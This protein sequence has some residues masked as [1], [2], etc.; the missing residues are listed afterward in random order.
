MNRIYYLFLVFLL[1][2]LT[3]TFAQTGKIVGNVTDKETGEPLIGANVLI[4]GTS[5]GAATDVEGEFLILNVPPGTYT[6]KTSFIGYQ[7]ISMSNIKVSVNLTTEAKFAISSEAIQAKEVL[8]VAERPLVD[9]NITNSTSVVAAEDIEN[10]PIRGVNAIVATQAGVVSQ[11]GNLFVRGSRADAVAYYVDGVLVNNPVFG[12][13]RT[14]P[15]QNAIEE[16]QFQ[17][18]GYPAE[19]GG[20]NAGIISTQTRTGKEKYNFNFEVIT[21][22][23]AKVGKKYLGG[24]SYGNSEYIFTAGGPLVPS[25]KNLKFF[26]AANNN[27]SRSPAAFYRGID[28]KNVYDP[29]LALA[30]RAD[31]FNIYYPAGYLVGYLNNSYQVQGNLSWDLKPLFLRVNGSYTTVEG[32]NGVGITEYNTSNRSGM[33]QAETFTSSFKIS[34]VLDPNTFYDIIFNSFY[35]Y[36]IDMD[37]IFKH[38]LAAYG[39]SIENA[40]VGTAMRR[41]GSNLINLAAYGFNFNRST[42]PFNLY[43]KQSTNS[44]GG[45]ANFVHQAGLHHELKIGGE[46]NYWTIRRYQVAPLNLASNIRANPKGDLY[47]IY[48]RVDNYGY[49]VL[50]NKTDE[51]GIYGPRHPLFGGFYVQDKIEYSDIVINAGARLDYIDTDGKVFKDPTKIQFDEKDNIDPNGLETIK[52]LLQV[53]P[54]LGFSFPVTDKTVF[55]AQYGKFVQQTRLRDI[56]QGYNLIADNIKGG[57]AIQQPVGFGLKPER[58]TQYQI[59]FRQSISDIF[60]FDITGFYKDIKDQIQIRAVYADPTASHRQ[61]YAWVNGDFS[62]V[63]GI[64][65]KLDLRRTERISATVDYTYSDA[66]GTGSNPSTGFRQ[67]WQSPTATPYF[68]QQIAPLDFNQTH[69]GNLNIDY[70]FT[71]DDG[72]EVFGKKILENFGLNLLFTFNSGFNFTKWEG[73]GNARTP[74]EPLNASVTPWTFQLDAKVD[75]SITFGQFNANI[76]IWISNV[77]NTQNVVGVFNNTGDAYDDGYLADP[78]GVA[79]VEGIKKFGEDKANEYINLYKAMIYDA[80]RFGAP[81]QIRLGLKLNY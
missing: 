52:A 9:K 10:L 75:K 22:N 74:L 37:P 73:Y 65:L 19:F 35:D 80:G 8:V 72:P 47:D 67:I 51:K 1:V 49:D 38:N 14:A 43:R 61:Y 42:L 11:G 54:R 32:R 3:I 26:I 69:T 23:F 16:I 48:A 79:S 70:R 28:F 66:Q 13:S 62:T 50:G 76:Y 30:G 68:P 4:E 77:L 78:L 25:Y 15:I 5:Y 57:F 53:S 6:L 27:F 64:E 63:K 31:T 18:G 17:A 24:Y 44:L 41:D 29:Q 45:K 60:A 34:H 71:N 40:K 58:T 81:R 21:D 12:G 39:D 46:F 7:S 36:Y 56:Y 59:G 2:P 55:H 20:A 33:N